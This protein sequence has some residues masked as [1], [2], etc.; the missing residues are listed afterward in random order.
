MDDLTGKAICA[1][2]DVWTKLA[3]YIKGGLIRSQDDF[4][5]HKCK[6]VFEFC[7]E[8]LKNYAKNNNC[9][10]CALAIYSASDIGA[11]VCNR[12]LF[13]QLNPHIDLDGTCLSGAYDELMDCLCDLHD[14]TSPL[15]AEARQRAYEIAV[16]IANI[17]PV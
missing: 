8:E 16:A 5:E 17:E 4:I 13:Y 2:Y 1:H 3:N 7:P 14:I 10:L 12:C 11:Y 6:F 9:I 15:D